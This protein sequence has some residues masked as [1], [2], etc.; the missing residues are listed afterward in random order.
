MEKI[1]RDFLWTGTQDH[2]RYHLVAWDLVCLPKGHG[3]LGIRKVTHLNHA[4]LA[5]QLWHIFQGTRVWK[6]ILA[7]KYLRRQSLNS[8]FSGAEIPQGSYIWNGILKALPLV[9]T[10]ANGKWEKETKSYFGRTTGC[11]RDPSSITPAMEGG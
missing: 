1:Q 4:L 9:K 8:L 10:K 3:G 7:E 6:D 11:V 5:N 2:K